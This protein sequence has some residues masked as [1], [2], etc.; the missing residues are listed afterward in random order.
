[1]W[2]RAK[3]YQKVY[4]FMR[5]RITAIGASGHASLSFLSICLFGEVTFFNQPDQTI[6]TCERAM[7]TEL[8]TEL[9]ST[10]QQFMC[11]LSR[12]ILKRLVEL[13]DLAGGERDLRGH[14]HILVTLS[15]V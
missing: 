13:C 11:S 10:Y 15:L 2:T 4:G 7:E 5:K 1:M 9:V 14:L 6:F 3:T 8:Y 12:C